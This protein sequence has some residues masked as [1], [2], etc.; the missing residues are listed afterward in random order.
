MP[1]FVSVDEPVRVGASVTF[2]DPMVLDWRN[3]TWKFQPTS[4]LMGVP[5]GAET[6]DV[7]RTRGPQRREPIGGDLS[8]ASFNVL[9]YFTTLGVEDAHVRAVRRPRRR[10]RDGRGRQRPARSVD[11]ANLARRR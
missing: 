3:S 7:S 10:R 2:A 6:V 4:P 9:N 5:S 11:P 8:V 1:T